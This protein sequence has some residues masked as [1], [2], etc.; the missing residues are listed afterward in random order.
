MGTIVGRNVK[1]EV[2][3]TFASPATPTTPGVSNASPGVVTLAA[4]GLTAGTVGF[5]LASTGM[6]ELDQ[7]AFV[8]GTPVSG[9]FQLP[10]LDTTDY[11]TWVTGLTY[12]AA[13]TWG[14][15]SEAY[16]Y[17][18]N[19]GAP[20]QLDDTRLIHV[21][22][23]NIAGNLQSEDLTI[24]ARNAEIDSSAMQFLMTKAQRGLAVL[25]KVSKGSQILRVFYGVPGRPGESV[26]AG[27]AG[28]GD[29]GLVGP[30]W[31]V[32]PNA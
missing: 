3:L 22:K 10:G 18:V 6:V 32:K 27:G 19:G 31:V 12:T 17:G 2:A 11:S 14:T 15:I 20:D 5:F 25:V 21:K 30:G 24:K 23:A 4:H 13:L 8:V 1:V 16:G 29:F 7:Q 28:T 26:D 9:S